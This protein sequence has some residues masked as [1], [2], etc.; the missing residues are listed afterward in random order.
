MCSIL[1]TYF[2]RKEFDTLMGEALLARGTTSFDSIKM[3]WKPV[4][5]IFTSN[6]N[7]TVPINIRNGEVR[8]M[9]FG[10]GGG[11]GG[12][13]DSSDRE[14]RCGGGGGG[15]YNTAI[16]SVGS[17]TIIP[18]TI[19]AGGLGTDDGNGGTGGTTS[20]GQFISAAGGGGAIYD[21]RGGSGGSGGGSGYYRIGG[22]GYNFG[23]G[24]SAGM[25]SLSGTKGGQW[26]GGG[27][28]VFHLGA[29]INNYNKTTSDY[30]PGPMPSSGGCGMS[31]YCTDMK[32]GIIEYTN[33]TDG[34][35]RSSNFSPNDLIGCNALSTMGK[36]G[37]TN[38][39]VGIWSSGTNQNFTAFGFGGGGGY[40]GNGGNG[41]AYIWGSMG[42]GGHAGGGGGGYYADGGHGV[43]GLT[44]TTTS[45]A[46]GGGGGYGDNG[47][48][49]NIYNSGR[50]VYSYGGGGGGYGPSHLGHGGNQ[51]HSNGQPGVC[52]IQ[53]YIAAMA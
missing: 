35:N 25:T 21:N 19:G 52:I 26:G 37:W 10:G 4:T 44:W 16:V 50:W 5:E 14:Q 20:F 8:V 15:Y 31:G 2:L 45:A 47:D 38:G 40:G 46:G 48:N 24:G 53:Y 33:S 43:G 9:V 3:V 29:S 42:W 23:G 18:I 49:G 22:T 13:D 1:D 30:F 7:W 6:T 11:R 51:T 12:N 39:I 28:G 27:G 41:A 32:N 34:I 17:G 36:A